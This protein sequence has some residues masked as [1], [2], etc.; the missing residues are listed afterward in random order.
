MF[1]SNE[2]RITSKEVRG[3]SVS[4]EKWCSCI[5]GTLTKEN[6]ISSI[7]QAGLQA[8]IILKVQLYMNEDKPNVRKITSLVIR[9]VTCQ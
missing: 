3:E 2:K 7:K 1:S 4:E 5:D 8:V 9:A 6:Y